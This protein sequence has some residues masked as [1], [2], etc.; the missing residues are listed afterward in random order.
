M[1]T[2]KRL[3]RIAILIGPLVTLIVTPD[4]NYDPINLG[5]ILVLCSLSFACIGLLI[6]TASIF[7]ERVGRNNLVIILFFFLALWS[8]FFFSGANKSQQFWGIF[9]RNTGILTYISLLSILIIFILIRDSE[10]YLRAFTFLI[11]TAIFMTLY[12]YIQLTGNDPVRW[13]SYAPFGTLGN[14]NF[15]SGFMGVSTVAML[16][17]GIISGSTVRTRS[18]LLIFCI[19][20]IFV[21]SETDSIQGIIA[22][23]AGAGF[24]G[25]LWSVSKGLKY[26][27]PYLLFSL[28]SIS[29]VILAL[30]NKG[31]LAGI[32]YQVTIVYRA[33]YMGA[34]LR[35]MIEKPFFGVGIDSYDDWYREERGVISAFRTGFTRTANTAHNI[36]IDLGAGGG[37]P[38]FIAYSLLLLVVIL[39]ILRGIKFGLSR[40]RIF[41]LASCTWVAYQVQA[42]VSIN[43]IGVGVWGWITSG[44]LVGYVR[45]RTNSNEV[46]FA[47]STKTNSVFVYDF[48]ENAFGFFKPNEF[49][50]KNK[51]R[52]DSQP[53]TP[54]AAP[55]MASLLLFGIGFIVTLIPFRTDMEFRR[56]LTQSDVTKIEEA[57]KSPGSQA[58]HIA[59]AA[60]LAL[61]NNL[62]EKGREFNQLL[63]DRYPRNYFGLVQRLQNSAFSESEVSDA[64]RR[65]REVDPFTSM[66]LEAPMPEKII[67][68][69]S[70]LPEG[71]QRELLNGWGLESSFPNSLISSSSPALQNEVRARILQMCR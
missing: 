4:W 6:P 47:R 32:I 44:I 9:G 11:A 5:K 41:S 66:C 10:T 43:Q 53:N 28:V 51:K 48:F 60:N 38:L 13:S 19:F 46:S 70:R 56:A 39:S 30:F 61:S 24:L 57:I 20:G 26:F 63:L 12:A 42:A 65:L 52:S 49:Q 50:N 27:V 64:I 55:V 59:Q 8:S 31:P 25:L 14:V 69:L 71:A 23:A 1:S 54:P 58:F 40:D 22:F 17:L 34:G 29:L 67:G 37:F 21:V 35:M 36:L 18:L 15:L 62:P 3:R 45:V 68:F 7:L 2:E 33:D 16:C